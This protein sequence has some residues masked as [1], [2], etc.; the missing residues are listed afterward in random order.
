MPIIRFFLDAV[1]RLRC[2]LSLLR[3]YRQG[4]LKGQ[5]SPHLQHAMNFALKVRGQRMLFGA[6]E[7]IILYVLVKAGDASRVAAIK[8]FAERLPE[9]HLRAAWKV[10][11]ALHELGFDPRKDYMAELRQGVCGL[12]KRD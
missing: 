1:N 9:A 4:F 3:D 10:R 5:M 12:T 2:V 7:D 6:Y 11:I 8:N